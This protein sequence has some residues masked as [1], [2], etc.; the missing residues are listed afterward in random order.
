MFRVGLTVVA[1]AM[2]VGDARGATIAVTTTSMLDKAGDGC[3]LP[4]ALKAL[5]TRAPYRECIAGNGSSDTI[6]LRTGIGTYTVPA[7]QTTFLVQRD[8]IIRSDTAEKQVLIQFTNSALN[9]FDVN[10]AS[11]GFNVEFRDLQL[12]YTGTGIQTGIHAAGTGSRK[13]TVVRCRVVG[14]SG[15]GVMAEGPDL[16]VIDSVITQNNASWAGAGIYVGGDAGTSLNIRY[17]EISFNNSGYSGGGVYFYGGGTSSIINST[18]AN[19]SAPSGGAMALTVTSTAKFNIIATTIAYNSAADYAGGV[20]AAA[21]ASVENFALSESIISDNQ[22]PSGPDWDGFLNSCNNSLISQAEGTSILGGT[23]NQLGVNAG[24]ITDYPMDAGG[25]YQTGMMVLGAASPA[26]DF[27]SS[28]SQTEDQ[29]HF[30]RGIGSIP[31]GN[32]FDIGAYER[33]PVE[34]AELLVVNAK[35]SDNHV[36]AS[37]PEFSNGKGTNLQSNAVNDYVTYAVPV[38]RDDCGSVSLGVRRTANSAQVKVYYN[39]PGLNNVWS[40]LGGTLDLWARTPIFK[41]LALVPNVKLNRS[42][43]QF[44]IQVV[45]RNNANNSGYQMSVDYIKIGPPTG[46]GPCYLICQTP[47]CGIF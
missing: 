28:S 2:W 42:R 24:F 35:S 18:V 5:N 7:G 46:A 10:G 25:K 34:Q 1:G 44:K 33:D 20:S 39:Q 11:P 8:A 9:A 6:T 40:P 37:A 15:T 14:F 23:H 45:G 27:N 13:L 16:D 17:S 3:S 36:V 12:W 26:A 4:E 29:R 31:G 41:E 22:A 43:T 47:P 30:P 19:N 38:L 21:F 32:R